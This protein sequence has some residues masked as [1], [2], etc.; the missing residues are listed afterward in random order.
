MTHPIRALNGIFAR[1]IITIRSFNYIILGKKKKH[2]EIF[3]LQQEYLYCLYLGLTMGHVL[4]TVST[5]CDSQ[6]GII[7]E[8]QFMNIQDCENL[9]VRT[10]QSF[11]GAKLF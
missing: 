4:T 1:K 2:F 6:C 7:D 5:M 9:K 10:S 8:G 11:I 3:S